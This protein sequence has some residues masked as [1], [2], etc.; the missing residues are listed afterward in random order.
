MRTT[1][2]INGD[3][4]QEARRLTAIRTKK[5][6]VEESLKEL[7]RQERLSRLSRRLGNNP[8]RLTLKSLE[9]MRQDA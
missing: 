6:L 7:I 9:R 1:I 5:E 3:L 8:L 4:L 2:D